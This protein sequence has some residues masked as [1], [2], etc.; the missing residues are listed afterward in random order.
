MSHKNSI[1]VGPGKI[2]DDIERAR[3]LK[4]EKYR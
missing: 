1:K 2:E 4:L 3:E